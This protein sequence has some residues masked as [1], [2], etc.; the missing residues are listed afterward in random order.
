MRNSKVVTISLPPALYARALK[1]AR[2][3]GMTRSELLREALRR[4]EVEHQEWQALLAY[5]RRKAKAASIRTE[6][7]VERLIDAARR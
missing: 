7:D 2:A 5:G 1:T 3:N 6:A 4:Y